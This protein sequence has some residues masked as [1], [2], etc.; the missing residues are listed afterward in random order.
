MV[1]TLFFLLYMNGAPGKLTLAL[2]LIFSLSFMEEQSQA[3]KESRCVWSGRP[4]AHLCY[5]ELV[6]V[7]GEGKDR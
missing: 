6:G 3:E 4:L 1:H 5:V 2:C 7:D